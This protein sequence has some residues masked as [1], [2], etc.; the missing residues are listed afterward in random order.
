MD[1]T[2]VELEALLKKAD[3]SFS[4]KMD[5]Y[6]MRVSEVDNRASAKKAEIARVQTLLKAQNGLIKNPVLN[7]K[8]QS[9]RSGM[10]EPSSFVRPSYE[11]FLYYIQKL[12]EM[13]HAEY[14]LK[15]NPKYCNTVLRKIAR[16]HV[17]MMKKLAE[18]YSDVHQA[19]QTQID[20]LF[21]QYS[22]AMKK[23]YARATAQ[24]VQIARTEADRIINDARKSI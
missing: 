15:H 24:A 19:Y 7:Q 1:I 17:L 5:E 8:Y 22:E 11:R 9:I 16:E 10:V 12:N 13:E 23:A 18:D 2:C 14:V 20:A 6:R 21:V 4:K 3:A